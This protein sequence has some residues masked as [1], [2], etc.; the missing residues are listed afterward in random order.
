MTPRVTSEIVLGKYEEPTDRLCGGDPLKLPDHFKH[1]DD[2]LT[3]GDCE[4]EG[5]GTV[6]RRVWE[7]VR[8]HPGITGQDLVLRMLQL[9]WSANMTLYGK[10]HKVCSLWAIG[11]VNGALRKTVRFLAVAEEAAKAA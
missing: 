11:Y 3:I 5:E 2:R 1:A 4:P 6:M 7:I 8:D 10:G 9:D